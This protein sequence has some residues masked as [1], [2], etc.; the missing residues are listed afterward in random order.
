MVETE[1]GE[2]T[3]LVVTGLQDMLRNTIGGDQ[4]KYGS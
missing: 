4:D 2:W 3:P 1:V